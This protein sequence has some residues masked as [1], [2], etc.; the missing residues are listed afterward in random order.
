MAEILLENDSCAEEIPLFFS[1]LIKR[2]KEV[3]KP[4]C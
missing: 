3:L 4:N 2:S 1:E